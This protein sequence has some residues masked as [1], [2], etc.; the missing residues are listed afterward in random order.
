M[1]IPLLENIVD[2]EEE[3]IDVINLVVLAGTKIQL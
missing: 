3:K 1:L 2:A